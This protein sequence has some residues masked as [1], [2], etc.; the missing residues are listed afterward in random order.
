MPSAIPSPNFEIETTVTSLE[1][2]VASIETMLT[3]NREGLPMVEEEATM[4]I[5]VYYDEDYDNDVINDVNN[6][7]DDNADNDEDGMNFG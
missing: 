3:P 1:T 4:P 6:G 7:D 2:T 5:D